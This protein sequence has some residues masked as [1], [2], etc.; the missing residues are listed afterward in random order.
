MCITPPYF[1]EL[2]QETY[3]IVDKHIRR[4]DEDLKKFEA[5]LSQERLHQ[6]QQTQQVLKAK[7]KQKASTP[8]NRLRGAQPQESE[9]INAEPNKFVHLL[10]H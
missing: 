1:I 4:L 6:Q 2:A 9:E 7:G 5:E 3:D 10:L 8:A